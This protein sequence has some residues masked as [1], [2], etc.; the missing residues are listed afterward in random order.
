MTPTL[1]SRSSATKCYPCVLIFFMFFNWCCYWWWSC[2]GTTPISAQGHLALYLRKQVVLRLESVPSGCIVKKQPISPSSNICL[3]LLLFFS[4]SLRN[5][6]HYGDGSYFQSD[7][8]VSVIFTQF[9]I[10][11]FALVWCIYDTGFKIKSSWGRDII[12]C[13]GFLPW[14]ELTLL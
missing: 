8:C 9:F 10:Y 3:F 14:I 12:Q 5:S 13:L 1:L 7:I 4:P 11:L 2:L 6:L